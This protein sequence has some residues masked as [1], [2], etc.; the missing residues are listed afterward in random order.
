ML[1]KKLRPAVLYQG[2]VRREIKWKV[3]LETLCSEYG[4]VNIT[5]SLE[6]EINYRVLRMHKDEEYNFWI[7]KSILFGVPVMAQWLMNPTRNH[8][9]EGSIPG[10][11][12]WVKDP[13]LLWLWCRPAAAAP[14]WPLAWE[15]LPWKRQKDKKRK[16]EKEK[17]EKVS[18]YSEEVLS[19]SD[20]I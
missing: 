11:V 8:E 4:I 18:F 14:S 20:T 2:L 10:L 15:P 7:R 3:A 19:T 1:I 12:Q 6:G 16:K 9:V 13:T 17:K 5:L